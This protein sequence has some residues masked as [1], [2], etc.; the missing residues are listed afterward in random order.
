MRGCPTK[1]EGVREASGGLGVVKLQ[2]VQVVLL[3]VVKLCLRVVLLE[4]VSR[5]EEVVKLEE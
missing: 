5:L 3:G 4:E 1:K 2:D